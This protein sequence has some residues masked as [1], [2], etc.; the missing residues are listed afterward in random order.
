MATKNGTGKA[1][2]P[3][4]NYFDTMDTNEKKL[5][6]KHGKNI[7]ETIRTIELDGFKSF[8]SATTF[9]G[10]MFW[11]SLLVFSLSFL[12]YQ[13]YK[14]IHDYINSP[15]IS[16]FTIKTNDTLDFPTLYLCPASLVSQAF[17]NRTPEAETRAI[18]F[19]AEMGAVWDYTEYLATGNLSSDFESNHEVELKKYKANNEYDSSMET[20]DLQDFWKKATVPLDSHLRHCEFRSFVFHQLNCSDIAREVLDPEYGK[21]YVVDLGDLQQTVEGQGL[22]FVFNVQSKTYPTHPKL[23]PVFNG[24]YV[25][26]VK[27]FNPSAGDSILLTPNTFTRVDLAAQHQ[28]FMHQPSQNQ[29]CVKTRDTNENDNDDDDGSD[30]APEFTFKVFNAN[31]SQPSCKYDCVAR[32]FADICKCLPPTD[33]GLYKDDAWKNV[34]GF[35]RFKHLQ[36]IK[37]KVHGDKAVADRISQCRDQC[38][39]PCKDWRYDVRTTSMNL[40]QAGFDPSQPVSDIIYV[41]VAYSHMEYSKYTQ[42]NSMEP[43]SLYLLFSS[44]PSPI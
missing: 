40:Y 22:Q 36:C 34:D 23:A 10:K 24:I 43:V 13:L 1:T 20:A 27:E 32:E 2:A 19:K 28:I 15:T 37:E 12:C 14:T 29:P 7:D 44:L 4:D 17:L 26:V 38:F 16:T 30:D 35:C 18:V 9:C 25:S 5:E 11:M 41:T 31:Y 42:A 39:V 8:F 21:C 3:S 33:R 6:S